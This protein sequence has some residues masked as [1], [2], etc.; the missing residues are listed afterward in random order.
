MNSPNLGK[1][2]MSINR[3][4]GCINYNSPT[5]GCS[6]SN[7]KG[8]ISDKITTWVGLRNVPLNKRSQT[9]TVCLRLFEALGQEQLSYSD[10]N[11]TGC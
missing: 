10:R 5:M 6:C 3:V 7:K 11:Q 2:L 8:H 4:N 9:Q 1:T